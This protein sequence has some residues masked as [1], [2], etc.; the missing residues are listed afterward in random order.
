MDVNRMQINRVELGELEAPS[1]RFPQ[2]AGVFVREIGALAESY[3]GAIDKG[4]VETLLG[5]LNSSGFKIIFPNRALTSES[6][7]REWY[8][9]VEATFSHLKHTVVAL[10]PKLVSSDSAHVKLSIHGENDFQNPDQHETPRENMTFD[11][12]WE[13]S[14]TVDGQWVISSQQGNPESAPAFQQR[15]RANLQLTTWTISTDET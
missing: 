9:G 7:Y 1:I 11:I 2:D 10:D 14:R 6:D 13:L 12:M 15:G 3:F 5:C 4:D 8:S